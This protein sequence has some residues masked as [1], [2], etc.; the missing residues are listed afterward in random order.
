M[1]LAI[2]QPYFFPYLGY[3]QLINTVDDFI[4]YDDVNFINKGWINRNNILINGNASLITVPLIQASQNKLINEISIMSDNTWKIKL[5]KTIQLAY[6]KSPFFNKVYPLIKECIF[7]DEKLIHIYNFQIIKKICQYLN[8]KTNILYSS[9]LIDNDKTLKAQHR[10]LDIC[11][12]KNNTHYINPMGGLNL[13]DKT[14][15]KNQNILLSFIK[16]NSIEYRQFDNTFIN[17]LSIIDVLMF[18]EIEEIHTLINQ[19]DL[20]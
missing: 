12:K 5:D 11:I 19:Y 14:I 3:F 2:M 9:E 7:C 16:M 17:C 15:F 13:Y 1:K 20:I 10:I 18:N 6:K 4:I 8:I